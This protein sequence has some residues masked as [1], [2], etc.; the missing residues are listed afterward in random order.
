MKKLSILV[1]VVSV[2]LAMAVGTMVQRLYGAA[3]AIE[4]VYHAWWFTGMWVLLAVLGIVAL[5]RKRV[6]KRPSVMGIHLAFLFIMTGMIVSSFAARSGRIVLAPGQNVSTFETDHGDRELPFGVLLDYFEVVNYPGTQS[7]QD[8]VSIVTFN[9]D[10]QDTISMNHIARYGGYH[11]CQ[12]GYSPDGEVILTVTHDPWGT[13]LNYAGYLILLVSM[14]GFFLDPH[15][16]FRQLARGGMTLL[17]LAVSVEVQALP[18]TLPCESAERM[19]KLCVN[20]QGRIC[21]VSTLARDF[22]TKL[23]GSP[24]YKGLTSEQVLSGWIYY[25]SDWQQEPII[26]LKGGESVKS[27]FHTTSRYV[28]LNDYIDNMGQYRLK[29]LDTMS[30]TDPR[31]SSLMAVN[32]KYLLVTM[33]YGGELLKMYPIADSMGNIG[34]YS[35]SDALPLQL[36]DDEY[37]FI[38]RSLSYSQELVLMQDFASLDTLLE[39]TLSYQKNR[40][41]HTVPSDARLK[42][43]R[44]Y[45]RVSPSKIASVCCI[46]AGLCLFLLLLVRKPSSSTVFSKISLVLM[47]LEALYLLLLFVLRWCVSRHVP[48]SNG[49]E[50]M[51]FLALS[52]SV[53]TLLLHRRMPVVLAVGP[54]LTGVTMMVAMMGSASPMVTQLMPV[55]HSPLLCIHVATIMLS[56]ALL[57]LMAILAIAALFFM[58]ATGQERMA[59]TCQI[60]VYPALFLLTAGIFIGAVW[61]NQSWGTYWSWDPKEVWALVT[62]MVYSALL[63]GRSLTFM[64]RPRPI[65]VYCIV[66]FLSVLIT[67]FGVNFFLGG[68]HSYAR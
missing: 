32:E 58:D 10:L 1:L 28:S 21:P 47:A 45:N 8:F 16:R 63:H 39:K 56:Y 19:G 5:V 51:Y 3:F 17:L 20:Y 61:A 31:Y 7:P 48:L 49:Y 36:P 26:K 15:S 37:L 18:R 11:F 66:A 4:H 50:T 25:Y 35:H 57:A 43:E 44:L 9:R 14:L 52:L 33:L 13:G 62:M 68:M 59:C 42:A 38:R 64:Q 23:Y 24:T 34:W 6:M 41:G 27:L 53:L 55:L 67:Y 65:L 54:L 12:S 30:A 29:M 22:T 2:V 40:G 60:V 46:M